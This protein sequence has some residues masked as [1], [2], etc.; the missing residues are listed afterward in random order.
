[1]LS[2]STFPNLLLMGF[3]GL[4]AF[5]PVVEEVVEGLIEGITGNSGVDTRGWREFFHG[6]FSLNEQ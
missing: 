2:V 1:M 5:Q 6:Q 3:Q 4:Q